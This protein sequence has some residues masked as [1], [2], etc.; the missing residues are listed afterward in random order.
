MSAADSCLR[1][2]ADGACPPVRT[3][4]RDWSDADIKHWLNWAIKEFSLD[5][6]N[7]SNFNMK[8]KEMC[9]LGKEGFLARVPPFMGDILWE[10]LD[11]MLKGEPSRL[12]PLFRRLLLSSGRPG[13][14][15]PTSSSGSFFI[16][17]RAGY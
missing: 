17:V 5:G 4:P 7:L 16:V 13:L 12:L 15:S 14:L 9:G 3:D 6:V 8:G 10:H 11:M 1:L 2:S